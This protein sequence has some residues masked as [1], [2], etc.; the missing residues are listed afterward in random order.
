MPR[1][2]L[3]NATVVVL[4]DLGRS[5]RMQYHAL[6]L[7]A[8][9]ARVRLV[10]Y[11]GTRLVPAL[12]EHVGISVCALTAPLVADPRRLLRP[13][14]VAYSLAKLARVT[15]ALLRALLSGPRPDLLLVQSPPVLP[16]LVVAW[17]ATRLRGGRMVIDWH[18][19][20]TPLVKRTLGDHSRLARLHGWL[21]RR[22]GRTADAHLCVSQALQRALLEH[23]LTADI[24]YDRPAVGF[25]STLPTARAELLQRLGV[26]TEGPRPLILVAPSGWTEEEDTGLLFAALEVV[27][28]RLGSATEGLAVVLTGRGPLRDA[29][30][31]RLGMRPW[32]R[33]RIVCTWLEPDQYPALL[34]ACDVGLSL[35]RSFSGLDLAMKV[36]D[37]LGSGLPVIALD[38][39]C[40]REQLTP[41][42]N[43]WLVEDARAL[44]EVLV[45]LAQAGPEGAVLRHAQAQVRAHERAGFGAEW[46]AH[47]RAVLLAP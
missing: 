44:A 29:F 15:F 23:G 25:E 47:A 10:G 42:R 30:Q 33:V 9:G 16:T 7:A 12:V 32:A 2:S 27:D 13:V 46:R 19:L 17:L 20:G 39:G 21:E 24:L 28:A 40:V 34:R 31:R 3:M 22:L 41:S 14:Y 43:G 36:E 1:C 18:N 4:G 45:E 5:P 11:A 8:E 6:A 37:L 26:A 35:H 38:H